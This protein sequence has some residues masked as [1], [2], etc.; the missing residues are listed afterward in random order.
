MSEPTEVL[1]GI[2]EEMVGMKHRLAASELI[3]AEMKE[4]AKSQNKTIIEI[5]KMQ[6]KQQSFDREFLQLKKDFDEQNKANE[7]LFNEFRSTVGKI[8]GIMI[9]ALFFLTLIQ[10]GLVYIW[11]TNNSVM[12]DAQAQTN[13]KIRQIEKIIYT[14]NRDL[15]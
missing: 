3:L 14:E 13:E 10:G 12:K 5:V 1:H 7:P 6:E 11:N 8:N 9:A 4:V 15:K 2:R